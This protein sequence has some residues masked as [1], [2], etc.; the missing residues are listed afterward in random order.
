MLFFI[1]LIKFHSCLFYVFYIMGF[2]IVIE[3]VEM[4]AITTPTEE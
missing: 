2:G 1:D 4:T 3:E